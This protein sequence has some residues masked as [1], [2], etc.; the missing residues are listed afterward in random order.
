MISVTVSALATTAGVFEDKFTSCAHVD[1]SHHRRFR[2]PIS[3]EIAAEKSKAVGAE[4]E[5]RYFEAG[6]G[7]G[8]APLANS[9]D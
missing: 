1:S 6:A 8:A 4:F 2:F 9:E 3:F 5:A 7:I